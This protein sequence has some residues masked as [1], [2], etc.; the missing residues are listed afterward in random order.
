MRRWR[1]RD[2][3]RRFVHL[4]AQLVMQFLGAPKS[5][6]AP[7]HRARLSTAYRL[8]IT[9]LGNTERI[10]P[11]R[12]WRVRESNNIHDSISESR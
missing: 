4:A 12:N 7:S 11:F 6:V 3:H 2:P 1:E 9:T 8:S 10:V 5:L